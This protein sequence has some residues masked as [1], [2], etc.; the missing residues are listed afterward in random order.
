LGD[1]ERQLDDE[2]GSTVIP[3][4]AGIQKGLMEKFSAKAEI[5]DSG[6]RWNVGTAYVGAGF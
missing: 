4:K 1:G 5:P 6:L 2:K 3:A